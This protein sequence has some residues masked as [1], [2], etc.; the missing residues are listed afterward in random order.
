MSAFDAS[1]M[2]R[3]ACAACHTKFSTV[4]LYNRTFRDFESLYIGKDWTLVCCTLFPGGK[5]IE[6]Y[7]WNVHTIKIQKNTARIPF[8]V[9]KYCHLHC[10]NFAGTLTPTAVP[11]A[12]GTRTCG[13]TNKSTTHKA[14]RF[15]KYRDPRSRITLKLKKQIQKHN[16]TVLR[17][18]Q[19]SDLLRESVEKAAWCHHGCH[20]VGANIKIAMILECL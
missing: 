19:L 18:L 10:F 6:L 20:T 13:L 16:D 1:C 17:K 3:G 8:S 15:R 7:S 11:T 12:L 5:P 14:W 2:A 4:P 9:R